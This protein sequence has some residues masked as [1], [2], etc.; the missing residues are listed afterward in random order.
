MDKYNSVDTYDFGGSRSQTYTQTCKC[1]RKIEVSTQ[2]DEN[3]E[4]WTAVYVKCV[5]G[6]SV[7]FNLPVN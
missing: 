1:G 4:Y 6:E 3:P 2:R 5:C 7:A